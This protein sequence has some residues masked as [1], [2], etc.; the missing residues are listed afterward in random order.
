V[1][2]FPL[3]L[4]EILLAFFRKDADPVKPDWSGSTVSKRF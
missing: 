4:E 2:V 1:Q 3:S